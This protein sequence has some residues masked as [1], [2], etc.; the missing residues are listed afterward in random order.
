MYKY[1]NLSPGSIPEVLT[2]ASAAAVYCTQPG[3]TG[4]IV[5]NMTAAGSTVTSRD[6]VG[7]YSGSSPQRPYSVSL[8]PASVD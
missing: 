2:F 4:R 3:F 5:S 7:G 1:G 6:S 8:A